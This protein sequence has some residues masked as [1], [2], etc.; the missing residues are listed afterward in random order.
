MTCSVAMETLSR[1]FDYLPGCLNTDARGMG[2]RDAAIG[3]DLRETLSDEGSWSRRRQCECDLHSNSYRS[4]Q[5]EALTR[6]ALLLFGLLQTLRSK[7]LVRLPVQSRT[8]HH[9]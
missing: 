6:P 7:L 8:Q 4:E 3:D 9:H 2:A 5:V 1:W